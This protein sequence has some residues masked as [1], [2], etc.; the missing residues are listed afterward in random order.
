MPPKCGTAMQ[1]NSIIIFVDHND[2]KHT[3]LLVIHV[4]AAHFLFIAMASSSNQNLL[5]NRW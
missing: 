4:T 5:Y 2:V 1:P 3:N